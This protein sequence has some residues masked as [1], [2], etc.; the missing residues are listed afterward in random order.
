MTQR[1]R[2]I[3]LGLVPIVVSLLITA[4]LI[5]LA[6]EDPLAVFG[7][8][9]TGAFGELKSLAGVVNFW[10]PLTLVC[11]GLLVTFTTGLWNIGVEGQM[12][13]GA[14]LASWVARTLDLPAPLL[15]T[16][17]VLASAFGGAVYALVV[18]FLKTRLGIHE[19]FG[20]VA[21]NALAN[22]YAIYLI[23]GPWKPPSGGNAQA[24]DLFPEAARIPPLSPDFPVDL[25][26]LL[27]AVFALVLV[28]LALR[29]TR[30]GLELKA[31]GKNPRSALL[32]GVPVTMTMVSA[33]VVCGALAG[34]AGAHR[35]LFTYYSLRQLITG[36]IGF[37]GLLTVLLAG[38][39]VFWIPIVT[40]AF[41]SIM[42][43]STRLKIALQLNQS[44][45]GV[46]QGTIV[47]VSLLFT[48]VRQRLSTVR[49]AD[50]R[51]AAQHPE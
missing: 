17:A 33:L 42:S 34:I 15:I 30:W 13:M 18:G 26:L 10:I 5:L 39:Q 4:A 14:I 27:V 51:P 16:L 44:L 6:G 35:V 19:I 23:S 1:T 49:S 2:A 40:F 48:G 36:G 46:L 25:P 50:E 3:A 38:Q 32:L 29:G 24:T 20:G 22:I 9:W 21:F 45:T 31:T 41:A 43:G 8:V 7:F 47:L 37:L 28:W 12:V 11:T